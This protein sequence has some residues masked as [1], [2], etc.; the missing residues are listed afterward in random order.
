MFTR[1]SL[2]TECQPSSWVG[3]EKR[4]SFPEQVEVLALSGQRRGLEICGPKA[5]FVSSCQATTAWQ[6]LGHTGGYSGLGRGGV[7][8]GAEGVCRG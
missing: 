2:G 1:E 4:G 5:L 6:R 7:Q 8:P 3:E